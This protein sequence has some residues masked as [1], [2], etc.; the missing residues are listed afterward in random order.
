LSEKKDTED[1]SKRG[2]IFRIILVLSII[3]TSIGIFFASYYSSINKV[4]DSYEITLVNNINGIN[5]VNKNIAEFFNSSGTID[6]EYATK[7][8]PNTINEL[9]K[10]RVNIVNSKPT[11][12]YKKDYENLKLGLDNNLLIYRQALAILKDPSGPEVE[13]FGA[14]LKTYRNDCMNYYYLIDINS[15]KIE[16]PKSSLTFID[17]VLNESSMAIRIQK[18]EDIKTEQTREFIS[19]ID[20]ISKDFLEVKINYNSYVL[21]VR[22]K[23]MSYDELLL[24]VNDNFLKLSNVKNDFNSLSIPSS[25]IATYEAFKP[26]FEIYEI[27]L[28]DFK[29]ALVN[30]KIQSLSAVVDSSASDSLYTS[31]NEKFAELENYYT[32]FIKRFTELKNK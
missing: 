28:R 14:T 4:Y 17:N 27:Y 18:E 13:S 5:E 30:E 31:S 26:L 8:L 25:T 6:V 29:L 10:L 19:K 1:A 12:K 22:K 7:E 11:S 20:V 32:M 24:I 9:T 3:M 21:K 16:L 23:D 2:K 15:I